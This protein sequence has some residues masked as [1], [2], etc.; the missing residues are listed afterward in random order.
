[1]ARAQGTDLQ[2]GGLAPPPTTDMTAPPPP[3]SQT[4]RD[5][6]EAEKEDS[7]RGLEFVWLNGEIGVQHLGLQTFKANKLVDAAVV[8]TTQSGLLFGGGLGLR[9]VFVTAGARFRLGN[10]SDWQLWTL[11]GEVGIR[12][13]IGVIEP[14]FDLAAGYASMGH[15]DASNV[16]ADFNKAGVSVTGFNVR[17]GGGLDLYL[18]DVVSIGGKVSGDMMFLSRPKVADSNLTTGGGTLAAD[19]YGADGTSIGGGL[20]F[21]AVVGLHF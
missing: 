16:G 20:T 4:E 12:V 9:L 8:K 19:V 18:S 2:A 7:G 1:V 15:F 11:D 13:P 3:P 17:I 6:A 10:F 21:T 5:L 14:Y